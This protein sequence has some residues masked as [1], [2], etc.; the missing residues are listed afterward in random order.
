[1]LIAISPVGSGKLTIVSPEAQVT[2][3]GRQLEL[4]PPINWREV[5]GHR[6]LPELIQ[7]IS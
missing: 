3:P 2:G 7:A 1:M 6:S 4:M 5:I